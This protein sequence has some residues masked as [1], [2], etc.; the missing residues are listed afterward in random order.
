MMKQAFR[1]LVSAIVCASPA[2]A[3]ESSEVWFLENPYGLVRHAS[4]WL[5]NQV[6]DRCWTNAATVK[7]KVRLMLEQN[8]IPVK[9]DASEL[10]TVFSVGVLVKGLGFREAN[11]R[12]VVGAIFEVS[13][14]TF[15]EYESGRPGDDIFYLTMPGLIFRSFSII[16]SEV[17][18]NQQ[19]DEFIEGSSAE[20]VSNVLAGRR[21]E[22][23]REL[24]LTY[25][26][27]AD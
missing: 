4:L 19:M 23:V 11:G 5:D 12:C 2:T 7:S 27:L 24:F 10:S 8:S 1:T 17:D 18:V 26:K 9:D 13:G 16:T 22:E 6:Q 25:P 3:Q 15:E 21:A 14:H 20:Y